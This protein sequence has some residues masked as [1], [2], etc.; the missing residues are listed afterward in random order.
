[1]TI[2]GYFRL[3]KSIYWKLNSPIPFFICSLFTLRRLETNIS[4]IITSLRI[5]SYYGNLT[6]VVQGKFIDTIKQTLRIFLTLRLYGGGGGEMSDKGK[7]LNLWYTP[8]P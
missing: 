4:N 6:K 7:I 5:N 1:M 8:Y 2:H 3:F